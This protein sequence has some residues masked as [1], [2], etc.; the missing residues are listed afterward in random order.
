MLGKMHLQKIPIATTIRDQVICL[1]PEFFGE[2]GVIIGF[3]Y[4]KYEVMFYKQSFGKIDLN[5]LCS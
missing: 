4:N 1:K 3:D 5:G 2:I